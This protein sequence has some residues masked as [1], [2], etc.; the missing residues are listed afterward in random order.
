M[1]RN[2]GGLQA[3]VQAA[4]EELANQTAE[5]SAGGGMVVAK[6]NGRLD[7]VDLVIEPDVAADDVELLEDMIKA[8]VCQAMDKA[9]DLQRQEFSKLLGGMPL[10]PGLETLLGQ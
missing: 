6:V 10:P 1:M 2:L 5:G 9:R 7:L 4:Q 8:A 3:K